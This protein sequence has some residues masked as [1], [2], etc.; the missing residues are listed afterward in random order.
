MNLP[1]SGVH[2]RAHAQS[3]D[4]S[5]PL[6]S[7][8]DAF[9][10]PKRADGSDCVYLCGHSLG[11][12]PKDTARILNEELQN[13]AQLAVDGHFRSRRPWLPYHEQLAA[14]LARL[15]GASPTEVVAM[16]TLTVNL[17]LMLTSF[18]RPTRE[19]S[20]ILIE[21]RAFSSD[22]YAVASQIRQHGFDPATALLEIAPRSGEAAI[23]TEDV[24]ELIERESS[25]LAT[26]LLPGVQFLSG[27]RFDLRA[28]TQAARRHGC[29]V[30]FDL[31]HAIGN[32]P[33]ELHDWDV[34]FAVW[35]SYKYLNGGPGAIGGCFVHERYASCPDLPRLA[36][37]WGHDKAT[38]FE[39]PETFQPLPGAEGWQISNIPILSSAP[40]LASLPLFDAAGMPQLR[41]K[42][43]RLTGYLETLLRARTAAAVI[44]LTPQ[45]PEARGSQLSLRLKR[46]PVE[47]RAVFDT[48]TKRGLVGDWREPDVIRVAPA[49]MYNTFV[50]VWELVDALATVLGDES[51]A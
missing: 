4:A 41:A 10:I 5:D 11:L 15:T 8:R 31:A 34:D 35:C 50:D 25:Q 49:P 7:M 9:L 18:Y 22:R 39:M 21:K 48:L 1:A 40:L 43:L 27:Q 42:S 44:L 38:R 16:N 24:C 2:D 3:L 28:I 29:K 30:G 45:D 13:W 37:W 26:V 33:L 14:P 32:V 17:H 47:A 46:T 19:R 6:A 20:K 12:Q 36:G 23:R 51:H